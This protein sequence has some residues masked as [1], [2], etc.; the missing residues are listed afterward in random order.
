M[1]WYHVCISFWTGKT[2]G[3]EVKLDLTPE[4][5]ERRINAPYATG[6]PITINGKTIQ[7]EDIER[8]RV[9]KTEE[10]STYF[11]PAVEHMVASRPFR[12]AGAV[13]YHIAN[14]MGDDVL[15]HD[16]NVLVLLGH[17]SAQA[18]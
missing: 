12:T 11:R 10:D 18:T 3:S 4:E 15:C 2:T 1:P 17:Q 8:V 13:D 6:Q 7:P 5:L 9:R 14:N 16:F